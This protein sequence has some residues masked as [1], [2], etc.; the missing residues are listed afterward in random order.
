MPES[1]AAS[2]AKRIKITGFWDQAIERY[3]DRH[4]EQVEDADWKR[5][6][7]EVTQQTVLARLSLDRL[8][9]HRRK[10]SNFFIP[11]KITRRIA[12]QRVSKVDKWLLGVGNSF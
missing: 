9:R 5:D 10:K 1:E 4:C 8:L 11:R 6:F 12:H 7:Y 2:H 3:R